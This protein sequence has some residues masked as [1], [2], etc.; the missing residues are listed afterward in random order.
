M[1]ILVSSAL[2]KPGPARWQAAKA[3][4]R[5]IQIAYSVFA[6]VQPECYEMREHR[7]E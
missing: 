7:K 3:S 1:A 5:G 4:V 6:S 2:P